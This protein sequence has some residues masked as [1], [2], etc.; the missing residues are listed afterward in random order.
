LRQC[1]VLNCRTPPKRFFQ[2]I[3]HVRSNENTF[4][5]CHM[6]G[7][8]SPLGVMKKGLLPEQICKPNSVPAFGGRQPFL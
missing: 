5:I 2:F 8:G 6:V 1:T 4:A 7:K 3:R